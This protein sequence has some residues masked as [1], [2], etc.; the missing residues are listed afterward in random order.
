MKY[1]IITLML[2]STVLSAQAELTQDDLDKIQKIVDATETRLK[3][4]V[5]I[6]IDPLE[7]NMNNQFEHVDKRITDTRNTIYALIALIIVAIGLPAWRDRK[8]RKFESQIEK[9]IETLTAEMENLKNERI[10]SSQ[11]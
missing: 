1:F 3:E 11:D 9:Q 5:N 6:K 7:K 10:Q 2:L 4:Y 8:D